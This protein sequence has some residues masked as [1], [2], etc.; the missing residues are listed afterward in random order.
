MKTSK[1][2]LAI[3]GTW[4][5]KKGYTHYGSNVDI[6][7]YTSDNMFTVPSD[8]I[9]QT[10]CTYRGSSNIMLMREDGIVLAQGSTPS[11]GSQGNIVMTN[12]VRKG[13]RVY[14]TRSSTYSYA[15]YYPYQA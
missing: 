15:F 3:I 5:A 11:A 12:E 1:E 8:G 2:I 14:V 6:S 4:I 13:M 7:S 9:I 10:V